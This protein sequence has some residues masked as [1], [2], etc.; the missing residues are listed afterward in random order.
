MLEFRD[1]EQELEAAF[2]HSFMKPQIINGKWIVAYDEYGTG[3]TL[4]EEYADILDDEGYTQDV[5]YYECYGCRLSADGYTDC[6]E[7]ETF[8]SVE[9]CVEFLIETYGDC[10]I[11]A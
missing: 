1:Q 8:D 11:Y 9:D 6:T 4:P 7:W 3:R 5:Q 10:E 2:R